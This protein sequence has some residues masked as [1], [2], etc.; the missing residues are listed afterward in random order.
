MNGAE[1]LIGSIIESGLCTRC[2]GCVASCPVNAL[3]YTAMGVV[4]SGECIDCGNCISICPGKGLDLS[5]HE[6]RLFGSSRSKS[7]GSRNG[8]HIKRIDLSAGDMEI[9]KKGYFGGRVTALCI[10]G[11]ENGYFDA[12]L[13]TDWSETSDLSI[14]RGVIARN[15]REVISCSSSKYVFSPVLTLLR[16]VAEDENIKKLAVV[17]LPCHFHALR[18]M[19]IEP[20]TKYLTEK[21]ELCISINCGAAIL[22]EEGWKQ[23][24]SDLAGVNGEDISAFSARKTSGNTIR[25]NISKNNGTS[26]QKD[27]PLNRYL[28]KIAGIGVWERCLMCPDYSGD[29]ADISFGAPIIRSKKA[30]NIVNSALESG[31]L[32]PSRTSRKSAQLY[33]DLVVPFRKRWKTRLNIW[34]RR[35]KGLPVP[36][37][38]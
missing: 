8:V 32:I 13:M 31:D 21:V 30:M 18:N 23:A 15:R 10:H 24:V 35:K 14:G 19:E 2:G 1:E 37:Y 20:K 34:K 17:G 33:V 5:Y 36:E 26:L 22:G 9:F 11:L 27:I 28:L 7:L 3:S 38:H 12:A 25:F 6:K 4:L 29:L 16:E